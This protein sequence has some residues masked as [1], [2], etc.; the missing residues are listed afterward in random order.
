[1]L[2]GGLFFYDIFFVFGTKIMVT[3]A[4]SMDVPIKVQKPCPCNISPSPP[5]STNYPLFSSILFQ[6]LNYLLSTY[7]YTTIPPVFFHSHQSIHSLLL[8]S[9]P[10]FSINSLP[11]H[12]T[13]PD[14]GPKRI[15][16]PPP[17]SNPRILHARSRRYRRPRSLHRSLPP[18]RS[19]S[20]SPKKHYHPLQ[21]THVQ[22]PETVLYDDACGVY[23][24]SRSDDDGYACV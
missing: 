18:L 9:F 19:L 7:N 14:H 8:R 6:S 17:N 13:N 16:L 20:L 21:T 11:S 1:M 15:H 22:V 23:S 5:P 4:V 3:V 10:T 24:G 12:P 2:L